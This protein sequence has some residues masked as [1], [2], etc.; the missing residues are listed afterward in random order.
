M[1]EWRRFPAPAFFYL[2]ANPSERDCGT[3]QADHRVHR[4]SLRRD[5]PARATADLERVARLVAVADGQFRRRPITKNAKPL[6]PT[7]RLTHH[8]GLRRVSAAIA[9][10]AIETWNTVTL[11]ANW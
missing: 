8:M 10:R 7:A 6:A 2:H 4:N 3:P 11:L 9:A 5:G 1:A